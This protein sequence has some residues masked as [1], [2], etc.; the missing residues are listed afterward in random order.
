M[1]F[2]V[3]RFQSTIGISLATVAIVSI[4]TVSLAV[5]VEQVPNPRQ[6]NGGWVTDTANILS[7]ATEA[8]L[9]QKISELEAKNGSEIAVVTVP[10][11]APSATPKQFA[12]K[13]FNYWGIGKAAH[14]NGVL[15]LISLGDRRV[16]IETGYGIEEHLPDAQVG[17]IIDQKI[18]PR[19][20]QGDFDGGTLAGIQ[21]VT[22]D[23][24][25]VIY[26]VS[27]SSPTANTSLNTTAVETSAMNTAVSPSSV[28]EVSSNSATEVSDF[29]RDLFN[30]LGW[31]GFLLFAALCVAA[32][33]RNHDDDDSNSGGGGNK[34]S[35][36]RPIWSFTSSNHSGGY[37]GGGFGGCSGGSSGGGGGFGGGSSGGGGA[38]GGF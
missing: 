4:P 37:S 11:T 20:K 38:G 12:T 36:Q 15:F 16:E 17:Q 23:L 32:L 2:T 9:N 33:I 6:V 35:K 28:D 18:V 34:R 25:P 5:S 24:A 22:Q 1:T 19:L 26:S 27:S 14:N 29:T 31:G 30:F 3:T 7:P 10:D 8:N 13:L 21:A